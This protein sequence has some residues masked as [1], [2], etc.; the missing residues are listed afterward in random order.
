MIYEANSA[1]V[2]DPAY[3]DGM[4]AGKRDLL[5]RIRD[6]SVIVACFVIA[7][8]AALAAF[9]VILAGDA[10]T[11]VTTAPPDTVPAPPTSTCVVQFDGC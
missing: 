6:V 7:A 5:S 4:A 10:V 11:D 9:L 1:R 8:V 2:H 3:A